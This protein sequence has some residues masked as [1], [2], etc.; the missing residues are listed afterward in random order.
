MITKV[1]GDLQS[2]LL[3]VL[4]ILLPTPLSARVTD[5]FGNPV[6]GYLVSW[7]VTL[8]NATL[9]SVTSPTNSSGIATNTLTLTS[10]L[11]G[12]RNVT[13]TVVG[14]AIPAVFS[15]SGIL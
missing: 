2:G 10:L 12:L 14:V 3:S 15:E 7:A 6:S 13:A 9:G 4:G 11:G 1:G 5:A 8:G